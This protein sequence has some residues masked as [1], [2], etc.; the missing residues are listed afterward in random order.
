[1]AATGDLKR[2]IRG[3]T[4]TK[5]ITKAMELV[6]ASKMRRAVTA[7]L[8]TRSYAYR[9][10]EL[11]TN[12]SSVTDSALHPLLV[13]REKRHGLI[14]LFSSDRGLAGGL[15]TQLVRKLQEAVQGFGDIPVNCIVYGKKGQDAVR[16]LG[17]PL[18][19]AYANP[20]RKPIVA[21]ILPVAKTVVSEYLA[22]SYDRVKLVWSDYRSPLL[23]VAK[24]RTILPI[25]R[26]ELEA[27]I[28]ETGGSVEF[29]GLDDVELREYAFEPSADEVLDAI[30]VRLLEMQL[31][32]A[33][34]DATASEHAARMMAMRN[35]S[36]AATDLIDELTLNYN[37]V[38]QASITRDLSE[39]SASRAALE[40]A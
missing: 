20:S 3:I 8:A 6:A 16:R 13:R 10:W 27:T 28:K 26:G 5:K 12:L 23:Q 15:T 17:L 34:L 39:I 19:A 35:A 33:L 1:M 11:L 4:S 24:K 40:N 22:G 37:Q 36:D 14:V 2:R 32:Q 9:A 18:V 29:Q 7:A 30:L 31:Y 25:E 21:D 38:R